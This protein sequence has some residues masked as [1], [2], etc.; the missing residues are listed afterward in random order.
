MVSCTAWNS[1]GE[2]EEHALII[3]ALVVYLSLPNWGLLLISTDSML[4]R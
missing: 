1:S 3:D 4:H 2:K